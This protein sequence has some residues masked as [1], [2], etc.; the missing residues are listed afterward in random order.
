M[1]TWTSLVVLSLAAVSTLSFPR[2]DAE[3]KIPSVGLGTRAQYY[4]LHSD[5]SYKFGYD[6]ADG[7]YE[8]AMAQAPGDVAGAFGYKDPTGADI[9]LEY[10]ADKRGF[11]PTG[12]HLPVAPAADFGAR[13]SGGSPAAPVVV[14]KA[15]PA[16]YDVSFPAAAPAPATPVEV[17]QVRSSTG[18]DGS[19]SFSYD[20]SSSSRSESGDARNSVTGRYSFVADDGINRRIDYI[21]G[22]D[23]GYIAEGDSLPVGPSVPGAESGIPTG[24]IL[25]VLSEEEA[26]ALAAATSA[27]GPVS[28]SAPTSATGASPGTATVSG[29]RGDASY[30]FS[31]DAGDSARSESA[32]ADL[33]VQGTY[34]F[35]PPDTQHRLSV[36]YRAGSDTGFVA[37][38]DHLPV[39]PEADFGARTSGG[40]PAAP[41]VITKAAPATYDVSFPA[42]APAPSAVPAP[43]PATPVEVAQVRSSTG[44]DGSY[45]FSYDASSSSRSESGDARNSVTGRYSFVADDGVNRRID[46]VAGADTGYIAEGDSLP[47]GPSVPGAESGIPT[48]RILP[49]LSE[50]EANALA[51]A[52]SASGPVSY[53]APTSA[54]GA[55]P[56]TATVSGTR[57]DASY[58]FSYDAGDSARS[59]S[60]DADLNVQGTYSFVPP[61]TQHRLSVHYRAGSDTGFVATGDHLP[62]APEADFG[63]RTSGGSPAAP[64]ITKAAPTTYDASAPAAAAPAAPS[65]APAPGPATPVEVAQ[66]R[67]ST[68]GDGSY[69]FSYDTSSSSRSESAD[70]RNSV[71][72]RYSFVADDGINRRI[73]YVAGADT[74][75]IAEGD[76]LPIGPPVPGAESGVPTGRIVP[77]LSEEE[78]NALAATGSAGESGSAA[79]AYTAPTAPGVAT[80]A[81]TGTPGLPSSS[82]HGDAA[83]AAA[84]SYSAPTSATQGVTSSGKHSSHVVGDVLVHQ[85]SPTN[86]LKYGYSF[87]AVRR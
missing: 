47:V 36:H 51:A 79:V 41:V 59:E 40:S 48:G 56:G 78:A 16:T 32:D 43:G 83:A 18:D 26:N 27:S 73:D 13:T 71:T 70:A 42:A 58:S 28:Y 38:G 8:Q 11:L 45:S 54:T 61:D 29:T 10:T 62:V 84:T 46:Y 66:V 85:Y 12:A 53:S 86:A 2:P 55:S 25:P 63:A 60:A 76:S 15:A 39:A 81:E 21:S 67:S 72:G 3:Y 23:T 64:V 31:Y 82:A 65:A 77:V 24:R 5:G 33:N 80:A 57:G 37:T 20:A 6:T 34:S 4:V 75:Y 44:D 30:S 19:Y 50:E 87:S 69:S 35:V 74:G 68:G 22:A 52:T 17:A 9:K 14:T 7:I 1:G 49:V